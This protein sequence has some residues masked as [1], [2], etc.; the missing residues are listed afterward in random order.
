MHVT[1]SLPVHTPAWHVS[2]CVHASPSAHAVPF[3]CVGLLH[4]PVLG[5]HVPA[6]WHPSSAV[7]VTSV[8][9]RQTPA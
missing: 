4:T 5:S 7:H 3:A 1:R 2:V 8:P 6:V 9:P